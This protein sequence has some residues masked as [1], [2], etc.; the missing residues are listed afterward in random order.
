MNRSGASGQTN[1]GR[2]SG[3]GGAEVTESV[4]RADVRGKADANFEA[5]G[6]AS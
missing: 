4:R 5:R 2:G 6:S 1:L 3:F